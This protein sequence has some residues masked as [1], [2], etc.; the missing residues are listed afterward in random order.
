MRRVASTLGL[1]ALLAASG[2]AGPSR[3]YGD[4]RLKAA[5]TA[6]AAASQVQT[7][8]LAVEAAAKHKATGPYLSVLLGNSED[9][10]GSVQSA[11]SSVQ[12]PDEKADNLHDQL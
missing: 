12:P 11:F 5:N 9:A 7:A 1:A 8:R 3:T 10:L 6:E 2:C 4:Y